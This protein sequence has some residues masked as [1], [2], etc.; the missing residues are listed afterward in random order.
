MALS[1][2]DMS[3]SQ[4]WATELITKV[5]QNQ[6]LDRL[7]KQT[8]ARLLPSALALSKNYSGLR[9]SALQRATLS[10]KTDA[11]R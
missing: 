8:P 6:S 1:D 3:D 9:L 10:G 7:L 11:G 2:R 4:G 5:E